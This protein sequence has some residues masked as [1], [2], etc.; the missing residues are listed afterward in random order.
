MTTRCT[1]QHDGDLVVFLIGMTINKPW[2][3]DL[4]VPVFTAMPRMLTELSDADDSGLLGYEY[5]L[6][7]PNPTVLQYWN[8]LDKLYAY[9]SGRD[10]LHLPA[11]RRFNNLARKNPGAVGIWHETHVVE[12]AESIYNA[13]GDI[14]LAKATSRVPVTPA[15][16]RARQ[17][18]RRTTLAS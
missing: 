8:S 15:R 5:L 1:H 7:G 13:A 2:R 11:W 12:R 9:A 4:W 6:M 10:G 14:G 3:P 18:I 17:R 16:N